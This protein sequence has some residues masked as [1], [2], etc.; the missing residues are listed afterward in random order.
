M[1]IEI[2]AWHWSVIKDALVENIEDYR[3]TALLDTA[4]EDTREILLKAAERREQVLN[5]LQEQVKDYE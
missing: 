4:T 3:N 5:D 2:S 1:K